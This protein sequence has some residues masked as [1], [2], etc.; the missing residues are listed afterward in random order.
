MRTLAAQY[1]KWA[2]KTDLDDFWT[3]PK[4]K[5]LYKNHIYAMTSRTNVYNGERPHSCRPPLVSADQGSGTHR[6]TH[7]TPCAVST[8]GCRQSMRLTL[9]QAIGMQQRL[10]QRRGLCCC[11]YWICRASL[12]PRSVRGFA[13]SLA[14]GCPGVAKRRRAG[15]PWGFAQVGDT[16]TTRPSLAG[17]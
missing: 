17:T 5:R 12:Q 7:M 13:Y 8:V 3:D 15:S 10:P 14:S 1:V 16:G 2:N 9:Q 11:P 6:Q 4:V